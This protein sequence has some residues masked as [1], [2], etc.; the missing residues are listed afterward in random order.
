MTLD[1]TN[2]FKTV[3][4]KLMKLRNSCRTDALVIVNTHLVCTRVPAHSV[5]IEP[6]NEFT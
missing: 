6:V 2:C 5:F 1:G 4:A 3:S